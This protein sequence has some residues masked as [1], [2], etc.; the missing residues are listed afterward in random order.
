MH[1]AGAS[2]SSVTDLGLFL[3]DHCNQGFVISAVLI[4]AMELLA[5][6][7][8]ALTNLRFN[9]RLPNEFFCKVNQ[10]SSS[11]HKL[12]FM[13]PNHNDQEFLQGLLH[14]QP[15]LL[16]RITTLDFIYCCRNYTLSDMSINSSIHSL[17]LHEF[18]FKSES[19]SEWLSLPPKLQHLHCG[20]IEGGPPACSGIGGA[21]LGS[22]LSLELDA[23]QSFPCIPLH[24]LSQILQAAPLFQ[25]VKVDNLWEK[26]GYVIYCVLNATTAA[27]IAADM[28]LL[29]KKMCNLPTIRDGE[30]IIRCTGRETISTSLRPS[31]ATL[32]VM[33]GVTKCQFGDLLQGELA[34]LLCVFPNVQELTLGFCNEMTDVELQDVA[35]FGQQVTRLQIVKCCRLTTA[36]LYALCQSL[37]HMCSVVCETCPRLD[38]IAL[39]GCAAL[40]KRQDL[41]VTMTDTTNQ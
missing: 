39:D 26:K 25:L 8:P 4:E 32:P 24:A 17:K 10:S 3:E 14:L 16:P 21:A 12:T 7:C 20:R 15:S 31:I 19:E 37:P 18:C 36:S 23:T 30:F 35:E 2:L 34:L 5:G 40:L 22:L 6:A 38:Q 27:A 11:L 41:L 9:S 28:A 1:E 33:T 29:R 13:D